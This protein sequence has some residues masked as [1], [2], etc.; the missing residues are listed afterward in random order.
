[1]PDLRGAATQGG[2]VLVAAHGNS[3]RALR[4][5]LQDI[6]DDEITEL[7]VPTG[8]PFRL[9]LNDDLTVHAADYLGD[10]SAAAAAAAAVAR[11][12]DQPPG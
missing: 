2:A 7:E 3:I 1:V 12:A 5:H 8:I 6:A 10:A 4:K 11:Q 9:Q